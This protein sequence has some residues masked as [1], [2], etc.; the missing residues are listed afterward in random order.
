MHGNKINLKSLFILFRKYEETNKCNLSHVIVRPS[1][2]IFKLI[3]LYLLYIL[4]SILRNFFPQ[5]TNSGNSIRFI[6][7]ADK[8][9]TLL[10]LFMI[11]SLSYARA[12]YCTYTYCTFSIRSMF[13]MINC[14]ASLIILY[15]VYVVPTLLIH[16]NMF[17]FVWLYTRRHPPNS[18]VHNEFFCH[19]ISLQRAR[20]FQKILPVG[21][22]LE[23][24]TDK[25]DYNGKQ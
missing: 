13:V 11:L 16:S 1:N 17:G 12:Y 14:S 2:F 20:I 3:I 15:D 7:I 8:D 22:K 4:Y 6:K 10:S 23:Y 25:Y 24:E 21:K 9:Y 18:K 5:I 19:F